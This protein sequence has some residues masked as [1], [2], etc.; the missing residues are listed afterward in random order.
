MKRDDSLEGLN[1]EDFDHRILKHIIEIA[2]NETSR[3]MH[4]RKAIVRMGEE[5]LLEVT[6]LLSAKNKVIRWEAAKILQQISSEKSIPDLIQLLEDDDSDIRW[7][8]AVGLIDIGRK[9]I[10]PLLHEIINNNNSEFLRSGAHHI[11]MKLLELEEKKKYKSL[12]KSLKTTAV[13][14]EVASFEA[15]KT[16]VDL[17]K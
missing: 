15:E 9:S 1:L 6:K 13:S 14:G 11:L 5:M 2:G 10:N 8:A 7:I 4:A 3:K 17:N 12:L 16:F